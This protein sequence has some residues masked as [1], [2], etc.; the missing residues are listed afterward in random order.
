MK[1]TFTILIAAIAA[2]LLI[3]QP[4][5]ALAEKSQ[6]TYSNFTGQGTSGGGGNITTGATIGDIKITGTNG[7]GNTSY[8][9]VY[10]GGT[11]TITPLNGAT[12]T[13]IKLT[14]TTTSY[15][16]TWTASDA[17]TVSISSNTATW[18]GS[19]TT[20]IILT[21][22]A[23]AQARIT[24]ID[25]TYTPG[26]GSSVTAPS[27]T[28]AASFEVNKD[29]TI[30][31]AAET[32]V[33]Y[34]TDN[35]A[36][37]NTNP[38]AI[39]IGATETTFKIKATTTVNAIAYKNEASSS[40]VT[41]TYTKTTHNIS[42]VTTSGSNYTVVGTVVA[43]SNNG[44]VIGD[45]TGYVYSYKS[46]SRSVGDKLKIYN[47]KLYDYNKVLEFKVTGTIV[48]LSNYENGEATP[49]GGTEIESYA[50]GNHL[51]D[52]V[53]VEGMFT[54]SSAS[55]E[56]SGYNTR[57]VKV[58]YP[59]DEQ[60][61]LLEDYDGKKVRL[62][63][64]FTGFTGSAANSDFTIMYESIEDLTPVVE[65]SG[66]LNEFTY[67]YG[68]GPSAAQSINVSGSLLTA[69]ITVSAS[70]NYEVSLSENSGYASS[71]TLTQSAGSVSSTP[72]YIRLKSGLNS[73]TYSTNSDKITVSS[74][75]ATD[76][77]VALSGSVTHAITYGTPDH[78]TT[79]SGNTAA[80]YGTTVTITAEPASGY[81]LGSWNITQTTGGASAGI[82]PE[83][84]SGNSYSFTMPDCDITINAT[85]VNAYTITVNND[86]PTG[87]SVNTTPTSAGQGD[88]VTITVNPNSGFELYS[89]VV[90]DSGNN[91]ISVNQQNKFTMPAS[92]VTITVSF[93]ALYSVTYDK[94]EESV[95]GSVPVDENNPY[96][97]GAEVTVLSGAGLS[98]TG[99]TFTGW[100]PEPDGTGNSGN[101]Y[102]AGDNFNI[103]ANTTLYA[104]WSINSNEYT[105]S[106]TGPDNEALA[107]LYDGET[108][109]GGNDKIEYGTEVT[110]VVALSDDDAYTYSV[111]VV[112]DNTS[113]SITVADDKFTM[114]DATVTVTVTTRELYKYTLVTNDNQL[115]A[116]KHYVIASGTSG[117]SVEGVGY[118]KSNNRDAVDVK[119]DKDGKIIENDLLWDFV[120]GGDA[121][122]G[123]TFYDKYT[124]S[125]GF[126]RAPTSNNN[127]L[128]LNTTPANYA[129]WSISIAS[130]SDG[131]IASIV[132]KSGN[133]KNMRYNSN[134][135]LFACYA[136]STDQLDIY[137]FVKDDDT[138]YEI[139]SASPITGT[140]SLTT[141]F[142]K[143]KLTIQNNAVISV[144]G[145]ITNSTAKADSLVIENGGQLIFP[146]N[147]SVKA[148]VQNST[149][150]S[151]ETKDY[152][153]QWNAISSPVNN[154]LIENFVKG[155][156]N[157]Y[158]Y[159]VQTVTWQEYRNDD[160]GFDNLQ[161]GRGYIYRST[162]AG[163]EFKGDV[164]TGDENGLV[165][166]P[167]LSY[168]CNNDKYLGFNL[169]GNPFTHNITWT[170]L[171]T[172]T[173]ISN[174]GFFLLGANGEWTTQ[175][176][177]GTIAPMQ[178]FM[179]Q[180]T[181][182][183]PVV[184]I[185][186]V[187]GGGKGNDNRYGDDQIQFT[188]NNAE[189]FDVA[190]VIFKEGYG[191]N[192]IE[193][194]NADIPM[195][196]IINN[197]Q[198]FAIAAMSDNTS[199]INLGFKSTQMSQYTI[200]IKAEGNYSYM[201]LIDKLTGNDIDMLL[202]DSYTFIG[203]SSDRKDRFVLRLNYNAANIDAESEIFAYQSGSDI[204]VSGE[205]ELQIF[206]ITGR[207]VMTTTIS[208]V[209]TINVPTMGVYIFR[210]V[211][212]E[213]K[214]QKIVVR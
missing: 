6:F 8:L 108:E 154:A 174:D 132:A 163:I 20:E 84:V 96:R 81:K 91:T 41:R 33:W 123:W 31:P 111:S 64:F 162:E 140:H 44:F 213:I 107:A 129:K 7:Y 170:N 95:T 46:H 153:S 103:A 58:S 101:N 196:Y 119:F 51:S 73:G 131:Y 194:R 167:A 181:D 26:G 155:T 43:I 25:V 121:T 1:K 23:S 85:F 57:K 137:L 106:V 93:I 117:N 37:S 135:S 18:S 142:V 141:L 205:G 165:T 50:S 49:I 176:T 79:L 159:D 118:Q 62:K 35:S 87:G 164:I 68:S 52:Y 124:N 36:P 201:H 104:Q 149:V 193:H 188:V 175:T 30:T 19:S 187:A 110:V 40:V 70:S 99:H 144:S 115:V 72:V 71:V 113:E 136:N 39:H 116:G 152:I 169:I 9:Q 55:V 212:S 24:N 21:N 114:P 184:K 195:L 192:K 178:A 126:L 197:N 11:L 150:A 59:T 182:N 161:N 128:T 133:R 34:T 207:P 16:K 125:E 56:I 14:A 92:N 4:T 82:T 183:S 63:G 127:Y 2:I 86:T 151:T 179:I 97:D 77:T 211:G 166:C 53:Q 198:D 74:T 61:E 65:A 200:S 185:S 199:V 191:L 134:N 214:T 100:N 45:G 3:T 203:S 105:L 147:A 27:M 190:Y 102:A 47:S 173:N 90:K 172:K 122:N 138:D 139:Y 186:N 83:I 109:I 171:T 208:G 38:N 120:L 160:D 177:S 69:N 145:E 156:H 206:D 32:D 98:W 94:N 75:G 60:T 180:A 10:S 15:I 67:G 130:S 48:S 5:K 202:D 88:E 12:I 80:A 76:V 29:I 143:G 42:Q 13:E 209:E 158:Q 78:C 157:V 168:A 189:Y 54:A 66:N 17:S 210:L 89:L 22:S 146:N 28:A 204:I 148:T 112:N